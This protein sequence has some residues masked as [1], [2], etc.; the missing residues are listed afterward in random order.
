MKSR[1]ALAVRLASLLLGLATYGPVPEVEAATGCFS[2][3][4]FGAGLTRLDF[5]ISNHGNI[6]QFAC[7]E[8]E[9]HIRVKHMLLNGQP[10]YQPREGYILCGGGNAYYD[11]GFGE[12]GWGAPAITQPN[13]PNT[14][15]LTIC[16]TTTDG[17]WT[18]CQ[19]GHTRNTAEKELK[20]SMKLTNNTNSPQVATPE[21]YF[22]GDFDGDAAEDIYDR[23]GNSVW[24]RDWSSDGIVKLMRKSPIH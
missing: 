5:C 24:G 14:F 23:T 7:P 17:N 9:E 11:V 18:L 3:H 15:P 12:S 20:F 22:D 13:G 4:T 10:V 19:Q 8:T 21:R 1:G 2:T 6:V 16:R